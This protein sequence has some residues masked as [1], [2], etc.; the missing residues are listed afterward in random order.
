MNCILQS[1]GSISLGQK[2]PEELKICFMEEGRKLRPFSDEL[3]P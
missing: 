2:E 3:A 1:T